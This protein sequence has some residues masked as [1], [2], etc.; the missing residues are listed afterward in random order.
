MDKSKL[1][2][3]K[4]RPI[5]QGLFLEIGYNTKFAQFTLKDEDYKYKGK[6]YPSL[7]RLYLE[8]EDP[9][10][11]EFAYKHLLGWEH[12]KRLNANKILSPY[13]ESWREELEYRLMARGVKNMIKLASNSDSFQAIKWL[14]DKGWSEKRAGRPT[15]A[16][17]E[18]QAAI[19]AK[20][21]DEFSEDVA[22]LE[23]VK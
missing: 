10:E 14:S 17:V 2:D 15:K 8:C 11:Y 13:F 12:W 21:K 16:D 3:T 19:Q 1:K 4:G 20:I 7:K 5:T 18:R 22:R 23:L 6:V 9:T